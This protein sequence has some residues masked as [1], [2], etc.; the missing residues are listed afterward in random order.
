MATL[1]ATKPTRRRIGKG[2]ER[3]NWRT[4]T[5]LAV[6]GLALPHPFDLSY[7][8]TAWNLVHFPRAVL[9]SVMIAVVAVSGS[10]A[11]SSMAAYAI[12]R[13]WDRKVFRYAY[14]Y[15]LGAMFIPFPVVALPQ[16]KLTAWLHLDNPLGVGILHVLFSLGFNI[17]LYS[18]FLRSIPL[19]LE[20][21]AR[22]HG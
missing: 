7:F 10:L 2:G 18:A 22:L 9:I 6:N 20:E 15:L 3:K 16:V 14:F 12:V 21:A 13:N 4:T 5:V 1:D 17:L 8:K 11:V 19:D